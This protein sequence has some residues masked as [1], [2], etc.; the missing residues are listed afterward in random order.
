MVQQL[1]ALEEV[2][3]QLFHLLDT[4]GLCEHAEYPGSAVGI[5]TF[6]I[7]KLIEPKS[8]VYL[9]TGESEVGRECLKLAW[10]T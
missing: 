8:G 4:E 5:C 3:G 9:S 7:Q 1:T 10:A 2:R 6:H